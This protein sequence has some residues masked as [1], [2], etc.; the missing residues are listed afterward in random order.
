MYGFHVP[1]IGC[2]PLPRRCSENPA[3]QVNCADFQGA[4]V[5]VHRSE[6]A[7]HGPDLTITLA[8]LSRPRSAPPVLT[9]EREIFRPSDEGPDQT[10][11]R[12]SSRRA[13]ANRSRH[14]GSRRIRLSRRGGHEQSLRPTVHKRLRFFRSRARRRG[15]RKSGA[16]SRAGKRHTRPIRRGPFRL[17]R[18]TRQSGSRRQTPGDASSFFRHKPPWSDA[19]GGRRILRDARV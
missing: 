16:P 10:G 13:Y 11:R 4:L 19:C 15:D 8:P 1:W 14:R 18:G 9:V 17:R 3:A 7:C 12:S 6:T 2:S 5:A